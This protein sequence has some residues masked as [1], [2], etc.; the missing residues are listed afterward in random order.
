MTKIGKGD[1]FDTHH[2]AFFILHGRRSGEKTFKRL[3]RS[4]SGT[5]ISQDIGFI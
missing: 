3:I 2:K 1:V 4:S 5:L